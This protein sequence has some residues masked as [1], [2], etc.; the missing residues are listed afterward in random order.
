M[1][2]CEYVACPAPPDIEGLIRSVNHD[3]APDAIHNFTTIVSY[4]SA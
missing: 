3:K 4:V 1:D 2:Y